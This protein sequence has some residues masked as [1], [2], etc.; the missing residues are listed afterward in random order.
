MYYGEST[1]AY[2]AFLA[3]WRPGVS[4]PCVNIPREA[5]DHARTESQRVKGE[6]GT[7]P[8]PRGSLANGPN[9]RWA[10]GAA[11]DPGAESTKKPVTTLISGCQWV[12]RRVGPDMATGRPR[13]STA[14]G[15]GENV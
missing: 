4:L 12:C 10:G 15:M 9:G 14:A 8:P 6:K 3:F 11:G 13:K 1:R 2:L 5:S 7:R